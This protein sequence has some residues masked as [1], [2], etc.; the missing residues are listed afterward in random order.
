MRSVER[1]YAAALRWRCGAA[2]F[3]GSGDG[4][5]KFVWWRRAVGFEAARRSG[6]DGSGLARAW[7]MEKAD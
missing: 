5:G 3:G 6:G 4:A 1:F 7:P 2:T